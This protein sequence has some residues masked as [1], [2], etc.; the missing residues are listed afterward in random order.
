MRR[1]LFSVVQSFQDGQMAF[2]CCRMPDTT[3]TK[4]SSVGI[5]FLHFWPQY[6]RKG[7]FIVHKVHPF[8]KY[9]EHFVRHS[10]VPVNCRS[11]SKGSS[12]ANFDQSSLFC[13]GMCSS[14]T[15]IIMVVGVYGVL[16]SILGYIYIC[17]FFLFHVHCL[18]L[19]SILYP[20]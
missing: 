9:F 7:N 11:Y 15:L 2:V 5:L 19:K 14:V 16:F 12:L 4:G 6:I 13:A 3:V 1:F 18:Q 10:H 17:H 20:E 8:L